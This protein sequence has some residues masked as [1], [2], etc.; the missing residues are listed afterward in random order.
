V[1]R[2]VFSSVAKINCFCLPAI[3]CNCER[4]FEIMHDSDLITV[5]IERV[6]PGGYGI[7]FAE[8][9]TVFV[10]LA[11]PGD[12]VRARIESRKKGKI[13]F[14]EIEE[15]L[16]PA[17]DRKAPPCPY[18]NRC[19][20]C[21]FQQLNYAAQLKA[22]VEILRDALRRIGK[23]HWQNEIKIVASPH[24]WNYRTRVQWKREGSKIGYFERKSHSVVDVEICP[25]LA[26]PLQKEL[27]SLRENA[28]NKNFVQARV[29]T[30]GNEIS[31]NFDQENLLADDNFYA[32]ETE[33]SKDE[34]E[35]GKID[36]AFAASR[37][38]KIVCAQIGKFAYRFSADVFFQVNQTILRQFLEIVL[39]NLS[40]NLAF[41]LYCGVGLFSLPLATKFRKVFGVEANKTSINFARQNAD[42]FDNIKF[43]NAFVGEWL[44]RYDGEKP[45]LIL[46]D[47]PRNGAERKTVAALLKIKPP[48]IIY[49][50]CNPSTLARDLKTLISDNYKIKEIT[51]FDFFPQTHHVET[52][53]KLC[54]TSL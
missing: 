6:V 24:E 54:S 42:C 10:A 7:G 13:V 30:A 36:K 11:A 44:R 47:P 49:L 27:N 53:V 26:A 23:I 50:S 8:N 20:G 25:I 19:G 37:E 28:K 12:V 16:T 32:R 22:K 38:A 48:Q 39:Q 40:G 52:M 4:V 43:E 35:T 1:S 29:A 46:L 2:R 15:I 45:D 14:A 9:L 31:I 18:F 17:P 51:A 33:T 34:T 41:D 21:D 3:V 5:K